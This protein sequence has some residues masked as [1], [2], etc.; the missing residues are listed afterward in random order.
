[1]DAI[2]VAGSARGV[3]ASMSDA[4]LQWLAPEARN[5]LRSFKR[6]DKG[7]EPGLLARLA[8][9]RKNLRP[10]AF[11]WVDPFWEN[12]AITVEFRPLWDANEKN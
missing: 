11:L 5:K 12:E 4:S 6:G 3:L 2:G 10:S 9:S 8:S 1:M 7:C